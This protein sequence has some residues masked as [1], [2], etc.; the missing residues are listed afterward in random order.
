MTKTITTMA[1]AGV[2]ATAT[3]VS[4]PNKAEAYP[5]WVVPA[6]VGGVVGGV[7]IGSAV[8]HAGTYDNGRRVTVQPRQATNCRIVRER[9]ASGGFRRIE[10]CQ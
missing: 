5:V 1:A 2:I 9:T 8:A 10:V 6:I 7:I 3:L 4:V